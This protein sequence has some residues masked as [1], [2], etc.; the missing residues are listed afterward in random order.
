MRRT[1]PIFVFT[2][3]EGGNVE[4]VIWAYAFMVN[5]ANELGALTVAFEHRFFGLSVPFGG[6]VVPT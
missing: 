3:A 5:F 6:S 4:E 2:G 1:L